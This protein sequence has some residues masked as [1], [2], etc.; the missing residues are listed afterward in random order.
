[1]KGLKVGFKNDAKVT[2]DPSRHD[3]TIP[4][5]SPDRDSICRWAIKH[6]EVMKL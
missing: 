6:F 4:A 2:Q 1:M 5:G 3:R